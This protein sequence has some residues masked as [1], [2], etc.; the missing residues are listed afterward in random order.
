MHSRRAVLDFCRD[1]RRDLPLQDSGTDGLS[2][3]AVQAA[4]LLQKNLTRRRYNSPDKSA[5]L[6]CSVIQLPLRDMKC[7][8]PEK[9]YDGTA[10]GLYTIFAALWQDLIFTMKLLSRAM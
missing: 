2:S 7:A 8:A 10:A 3:Q 5:G 1:P 6:F 9:N 4:A